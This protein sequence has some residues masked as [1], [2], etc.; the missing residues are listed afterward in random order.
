MILKSYN[1]L[2]ENENRI[3][4]E[5]P[6]SIASADYII[7]VSQLHL[8]LKKKY[9]EE[10]LTSIETPTTNLS[11][12]FNTLKFL[13]ALDFISAEIEVEVTDELDTMLY[14][15]ISNSRL[16]STLVDFGVFDKVDTLIKNS[17][18]QKIIQLWE[19][20]N[21]IYTNSTQFQQVAEM[22]SLEAAT[23]QQI[24]KNSL[25]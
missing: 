6:I 14:L 9:R 23:I 20:S 17:N 12:L 21:Y 16:R 19:Y 4:V 24:I 15:A 5:V 2:I 11:V 10:I 18:N 3:V 8:F 7:D 22:L 1:T 13:D 25:L